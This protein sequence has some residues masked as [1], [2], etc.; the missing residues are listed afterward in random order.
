MFSQLTNN[1]E[2]PG[3]SAGEVRLIRQGKRVAFDVA[4]A[5]GEPRQVLLWDREA[6]LRG[7][8]ADAMTQETSG[9]PGQ[10]SQHA[11]FD[12]SGRRLVMESA[13]D[14]VGFNADGNTE[15]FLLDTKEGTWTQ[16]TDTRAPVENRRPDITGSRITFDSTGDLDDD[17]RTNIDNQDGNREIFQARKKRG[18]FV[19]TQL[20]DTQAPVDN[21]HGVSRKG[22]VTVIFSSNGDLNN[23]PKTNIN[24]QDGN[25]E[26]FQAEKNRRG[27]VITQLTDSVGGE[28]VMPAISKLGRYVVFESTADLLGNGAQNRRVF[29]LDLRKGNLRSLSRSRFGD[30]FHPRTGGWQVVWESTADLTGHNPT[31]DRVIYVFDRRK[32]ERK[33]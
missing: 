26:I 24:N 29:Q 10:D 12:T 3:P 28:N 20:T 8:S 32:S 25:R 4:A 27:F 22:G 16:I 1:P 5:T 23:D 6:Y 11:A 13:A 31:G 2:A 30:N 7:Q 21:Q 17:P 14:P 18:G 9:G 33:R 19:I 15:I